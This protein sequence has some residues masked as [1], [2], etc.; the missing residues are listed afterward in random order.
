[1]QSP[2]AGISRSILAVLGLLG[3]LALSSCAVAGD[4]AGAA[5]PPV[6]VTAQPPA[7]DQSGD[8]LT[9]DGLACELAQVPLSVVNNAT[10]LAGAEISNE[11]TKGMLLSSEFHIKTAAEHAKTEDLAAALIA[12]G[13]AAGEL[14]RAERAT[15]DLDNSALAQAAAHAS[16][17][18]EAAGAT[19]AIDGWTGG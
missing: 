9:G 3:G 11:A 19:I 18:C 4:A 10:Q 1:M 7:P 16:R 5:Q 17:V 12:A 15:A 2:I 6:T 14:G 8:Y 13:K